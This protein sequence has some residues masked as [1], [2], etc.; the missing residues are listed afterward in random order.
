MVPG[1]F[2]TLEA[3]PLTP[4]GKVDRRGL[5]TPPEL[6]QD[7]DETFVRPRDTLELQLARLWERLLGLE[8]VGMR[9]NFFDLG[10]HSL[11]AVRMFAEIEKVCGRRLPLATLFQA[12]TVEDLARVVRHEG[13]SPPPSSLVAIQP[14]GARPPLFCVPGHFGTVLCFQELAR[15]LGSDQPVF[16][17]EARGLDGA[18]PPHATVEDMAASYLEEMRTVQPRGPYSLAGYCFGATVVFEMAQQLRAQGQSVGLLALLDSY[19][20][21]DALRASVPRGRRLLRRGARRL[22]VEVENLL[23]LTAKDK[24]TYVWGKLKRVVK[25]TVDKIK[26]RVGLGPAVDANFLKV[27]EAHRKAIR[28]YRPRIYPGPVTLFRA[29]DP[30]MH[31]FADPQ[32]GWGGL[33]AGGV[34]VRLID[35]PRGAVIEEPRVRVLAEELRARLTDAQAFPTGPAE[36]LRA[37]ESSP[38][39]TT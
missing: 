16:G 5:P 12:P 30:L 18:E 32:F 38:V 7:L 4:N 39:T 9:D 37:L 6:R 3:L 28:A 21:D 24:L 31:R 10:G 29:R 11:L 26:I 22:R 36:P 13:W 34:V 25:R 14:N 1:W 8:P 20:H 19:G 15:N 2:V 23:R 35:G 27:A 17:L 33:A